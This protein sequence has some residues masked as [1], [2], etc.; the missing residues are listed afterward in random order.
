MNEIKIRVDK[1]YLDDGSGRWVWTMGL[2]DGPGRWVWTMGLDDGPGRWASEGSRC[3]H[4][5]K[6][7]RKGGSSTGTSGADPAER[8]RALVWGAFER[9]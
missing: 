8:T 4:D 2:D 5:S 1:K 7:I 6:S 9:Q 3:G